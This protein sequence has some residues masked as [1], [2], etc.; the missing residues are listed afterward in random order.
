VLRRAAQSGWTA[1][2]ALALLRL[3]GWALLVGLIV[4]GWAI[5]RPLLRQHL[6]EKQQGQ[7]PAVALLGM[8]SWMP[9][10]VMEEI[11]ALVRRTVDGSPF[12]RLTLEEATQELRASAW[13]KSV[14]R[15]VRRPGG[16]VEVRAAYRVPAALVERG[17]RFCLVDYEGVR[18]PLEYDDSVLAS[19]K[20]PVIR[21]VKAPQPS[22]GEAWSGG[23]VQ[24]GLKLA[25]VIVGQSLINQVKAIDVSNY[26]GRIDR[27][28]PHLTLVTQRGLVR[29]G[30]P[31]GDE[32]FYEPA[33]AAKLQSIQQVMQK[34]KTIDAN[35]RTVDVHGDTVLIASETTTAA[36][37]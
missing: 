35:G 15:I 17:G 3:S 19:V 20:L 4:V 31:P 8:P 7:A 18:L 28:R 14:D 24:A 6:A 11:Q 36:A 5:G 21:G 37:R 25:D 16:V 22:A 12:D 26:G 27:G 23:D 30:R 32:Q 1:S 13:V 33:A 29:W 9:P 2:G 10:A 34:F